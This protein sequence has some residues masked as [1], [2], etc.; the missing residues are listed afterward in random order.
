MSNETTT[1]SPA[2]FPTQTQ[3]LVAAAAS[4]LGADRFPSKYAASLPAW[5]M[6]GSSE[7]DLEF[8]RAFSSNPTPTDASGPN[9]TA[10]TVVS[11]VRAAL[12]SISYVPSVR[13]RFSA[14]ISAA[15]AAGGPRSAA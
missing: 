5:A 4:A 15:L 11:R 13:H 12:S 3:V 10:E 1:A 6:F 9:H 2:T 7:H 8:L 14:T